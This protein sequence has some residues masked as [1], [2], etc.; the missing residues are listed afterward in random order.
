MKKFDV[1]ALGELLIDFINNGVS[2]QENNTFEACPGG[3][4]CNV[5]AMLAKLGKNCAFIGKVGDDIFGRRLKAEIETLSIN[6]ENLKMDKEVRTT[7]AFVENDETGDRSFSFYRNPGADIMLTADE[8]NEEAIKSARVF[9]LGTL[10]MT[11]E[12]VRSATKKTLKIS[13]EAGCLISFDPNLREM[14]WESKKDAREAFDYGMRYCDILKISD[15]E[16]VWF[17]GEED[18]DKGIAILREK[19]NIPLILFSMGRDGS[20]AYYGDAV[21]EVPAFIQ[22]NTVDTTGAGDT[23]M[24]CCIN[25]VLENGIDNLTEGNLREM[26]KFANAAA[27]IITTRKGALKAMPNKEEVLKMLA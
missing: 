1:I 4:I 27:S 25:Y 16:L 23:F 6:T 21:A 13:K 2:E 26:L 19:Y 18:Y 3:A 5:L 17:T 12:P 24:G 7:L 10:S 20:R 14:L 9:H 8:V 15:N 11:H 22:D